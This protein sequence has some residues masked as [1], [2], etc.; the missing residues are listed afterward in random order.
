[1]TKFFV[2]LLTATLL[3]LYVLIS[4]GQMIGAFS[5]I[6]LVILTAIIGSFL[7]KQQGISTL[8]RAQQTVLSGQVPMSEILEGIILLIS[9]V[10]LLTPGF[11]TDGIGL[12]GLLPMT[13]QIFIQYLIDKQ[14]YR[15]FMPKVPP[16]QKEQTTIESEFWEDKP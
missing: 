9:G 11:I 15:R 3:E 10:L 13:R 1:M 16:T 8:M 12:L 7:L 6:L 14:I 2:L 4:V 5:T